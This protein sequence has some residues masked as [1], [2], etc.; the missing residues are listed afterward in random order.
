MLRLFWFIK[1]GI[2]SF[3]N[4]VKTQG[5]YPA[6]IWLFGHGIPKLTGIPFE[7]YSQI[8]PQIYVGPQIRKFG[9][10]KLE[11]WGINSS[12]NMRIEFDDVAH[13][14]ALAHHCHLPTDDDCAPT[15]AQMQTG[16]SFIHQKVTAGNKVYIHCRSGIGRAPTMA[17]AY[18]ISRGYTLPEAIQLI[19]RSRPFIQLTQHQI[20]QLKLFEEKQKTA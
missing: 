9:K 16:A 3:S 7:K 6:I 1:N 8:T 5:V 2:I 11:L 14:V 12:V 17:I 20:E 15:L 18:F 4:R 10:Q 13:N 19:K